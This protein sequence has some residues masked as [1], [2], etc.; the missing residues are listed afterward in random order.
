MANPITFKIEGMKE[1]EDRM[2]ALPE[3]LM[4][5]MARKTLA[6]AGND[7]RAAIVDKANESP[8]SR[9]DR[10]AGFLKHHFSVKVR[11]NKTDA[12]A[13]VGP[14]GR[15]YYPNIGSFHKNKKGRLVPDS[16]STGKF[17]KKEGALPVASVARFLEFGNSRTKGAHPFIEPAFKQVA[18]ALLEK[19]KS[20]LKAALDRIGR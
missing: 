14:Q 9:K 15:M 5:Q 16:V 17:A 18:P 7:A 13:Y 10:P 4:K 2:K 1:L 20:A 11:V 12:A 19:I 8:A 6:E 3:R